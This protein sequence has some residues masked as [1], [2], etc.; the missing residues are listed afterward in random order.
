M[1][2]TKSVLGKD[3][4]FETPTGW[5]VQVLPSNHGKF[6]QFLHPTRAEVQLDF[7]LQPGNHPQLEVS[8]ST[9]DTKIVVDGEELPMSV[10]AV[11]LDRADDRI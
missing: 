3:L 11:V 5:N 8:H 10:S 4:T 1:K 6:V 2:E 9:W 7:H